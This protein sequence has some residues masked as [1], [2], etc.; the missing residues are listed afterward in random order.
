MTCT[1]KLNA[2]TSLVLAAALLFAAPAL[3]QSGTATA[4]Q[5]G[6]LVGGLSAFST[7]TDGSPA[8]WAIGGV[9]QA[10]ATLTLAHTTSTRAI[11]L[12]GLVN[13]GSYVLV[14]KQD[15]TGGAAS[16]GGAWSCA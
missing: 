6:T 2:L 12:T 1:R 5:M 3:A 7:V 13:G 11:N 4:G 9:Y 16:P 15:S 10:N 8:T 14:L